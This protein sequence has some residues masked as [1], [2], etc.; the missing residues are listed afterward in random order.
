[1][2]TKSRCSS[3]AVSRPET[4][5]AYC[6]EAGSKTG[7]GIAGK[8]ELPDETELAFRDVIRTKWAIPLERIK[9]KRLN[10]RYA[11]PALPA[12]VSDAGSETDYL[13]RP[14]GNVRQFQI[15]N[16]DKTAEQPDSVR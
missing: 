13:A 12:S 15:R 1:M 5:G 3:C 10:A 8:K 14:T 4:A 7:S 6:P 2:L 11:V 16:G 9:T